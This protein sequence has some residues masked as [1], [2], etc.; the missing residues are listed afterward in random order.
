MRS[1]I[2]GGET[3]DVKG[4]DLV[5]TKDLPEP[6]YFLA[7]KGYD[8]DKVREKLE[9]RRIAAVIPMR[10]NR[11][12]W[13]A[14]D[15]DFYR[16]RNLVERCFSKLKQ[17]RRVATRYDKTALSFLGFIDIASVRIWLRFLST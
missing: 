6:G 1:E 11:K 17:W 12:E 15:R 7:D 9:E 13:R 2:T 4:F 8:A 14:V 5:M 10:R 16:W 3:A